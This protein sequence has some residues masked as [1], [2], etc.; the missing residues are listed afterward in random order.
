MPSYSH[1]KRRGTVVY[2]VVA[3]GERVLASSTIAEE[4]D[5]VVMG[6]GGVDDGSGV[7]EASAGMVVLIQ[8]KSSHGITLPSSPQYVPK[9]NPNCL[10]ISELIISP[11][12]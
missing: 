4:Y 5:E 6:E 7:V 9:Q 1:P 12:K 8:L 10:S 3:R 2:A 11:G